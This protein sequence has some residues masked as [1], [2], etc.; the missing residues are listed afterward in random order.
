MIE[1]GVLALCSEAKDL[2]DLKH[3]SI[4][5]LPEH[6]KVLL[7][8]SQMAKLHPWKCLSTITITFAI[9]ME[10]SP[11]LLAVKRWQIKLGVNIMKS[12]LTLKKAFQILDEVIFSLETYNI[13]SVH[14]SGDMH[15]ISKYI[16]KNT[17]TV[18]IIC[19]KS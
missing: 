13:T 4:P 10:D 19:G 12:F 2:V 11:N 9:G 17:D 3:T 15:L 8:L 6:Y 7:E 1:D 16:W 18:V 14:A 5:F